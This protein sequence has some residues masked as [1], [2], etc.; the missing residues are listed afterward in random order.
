[1]EHGEVEKGLLT[2]RE[3]L[4]LNRNEPLVHWWLTEA[5]LYGGMLQESIAEGEHAAPECDRS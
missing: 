1:M 4:Q 3:E 5:Y 2:L